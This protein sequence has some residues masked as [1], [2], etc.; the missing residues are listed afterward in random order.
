MAGGIVSSDDVARV[1]KAEA[2][3]TLVNYIPEETVNL[4][5]FTNDELEEYTEIITNANNYYQEKTTKFITGY[6]NIDKE[7]DKYVAELENNI[8]LGRALEIAQK[9][10]DRTNADK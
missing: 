2:M 5:I 10:Y 6:E 3:K 7:W 1:A 9:A 4:I 8:G